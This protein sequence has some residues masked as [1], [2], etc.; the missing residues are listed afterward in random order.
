VLSRIHWSPEVNDGLLTMR[1]TALA[2]VGRDDLSP[3][4]FASLAGPWESV[5]GRVSATA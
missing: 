4:E 2:L 1:Y 3:F 5:M